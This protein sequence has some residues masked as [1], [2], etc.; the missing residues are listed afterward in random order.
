MSRN[1]ESSLARSRVLH[2]YKSGTI[3][4]IENWWFH[5]IYLRDGSASFLPF[6]LGLKTGVISTFPN[7]NTISVPGA[8]LNITVL[9]ISFNL[10]PK[11]GMTKIR[12]SWLLTGTCLNTSSLFLLLHTA[13]VSKPHT[14]V[15][16]Y[17]PQTPCFFSMINWVI[18]ILWKV[19]K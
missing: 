7:L 13:Q 1:S 10:D 5:P 19:P 18:F 3:I 9:Y 6:L 11:Q 2:T 17:Y 15:C 8:S 14:Q 4:Y 16:T 12:C